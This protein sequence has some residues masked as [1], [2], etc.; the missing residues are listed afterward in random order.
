MTALTYNT[1]DRGRA[2]LRHN[3]MRFR[4]EPQLLGE[5]LRSRAKRNITS[6]S[7]PARG[8]ET[9]SFMTDQVL[10]CSSTHLLWNLASDTAEAGKRENKIKEFGGDEEHAKLK[11]NKAHTK[12]SDNAVDNV[13]GTR[14]LISE[15]QE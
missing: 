12:I 14:D 13:L 2:I 3:Q 4:L 15:L 1:S 10:S 11:A 8:C 9:R 5:Y 6:L 7:M